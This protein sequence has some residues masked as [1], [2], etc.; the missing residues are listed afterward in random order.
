MDGLTVLLNHITTRQLVLVAEQ[1]AKQNTRDYVYQAIIAMLADKVKTYVN[2]ME[3]LTLNDKVYAILDQLERSVYV[4]SFEP[5]FL[6]D[7]AQQLNMTCPDNEKICN[8]FLQRVFYWSLSLD[9]PIQ[10]FLSLA[11]LLKGPFGD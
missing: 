1:L 10:S 11:V 6:T 7:V 9:L 3:G 5:K 2:A 8:A 4:T